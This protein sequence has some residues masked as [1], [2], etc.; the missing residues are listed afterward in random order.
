MSVTHLGQTGI[1]RD[2]EFVT[3]PQYLL[4][5]SDIVRDAYRREMMMRP[6]SGIAGFNVGT[7]NVSNVDMISAVVGAFAG[8][9][10]GKQYT[11]KNEQAYMIALIGA[12]IA[13]VFSKKFLNKP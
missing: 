5:Q 12:I 1:P 11:H 2:Q 3:T 13:Y 9:Y 6:Q 10:V 4:G 7:Y 8:Y